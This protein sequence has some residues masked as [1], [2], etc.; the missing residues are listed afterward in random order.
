MAGRRCIA[1]PTSKSPFLATRP[2][3]ARRCAKTP[4]NGGGLLRAGMGANRGALG[5]NG[6]KP[7]RSAG[8]PG[9]A[10]RDARAATRFPLQARSPARRAVDCRLTGDLGGR[11]VRAPGR[12]AALEG[13]PGRPSCDPGGLPVGRVADAHPRRAREGGAARDGRREE[14]KAGGRGPRGGARRVCGR[15]AVV[16]RRVAVPAQAGDR[17]RLPDGK[18]DGDTSGGQGRARGDLLP[19]AVANGA[20]RADDDAPAQEGARG[21]PKDP[22][23]G[24]PDAAGAGACGVHGIRA[25]RRPPR[26]PPP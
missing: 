26:K 15:Q 19:C 5:Q 2:F 10:C 7:A 23:G 4:Q 1:M 22:A 24:V 8:W 6:T 21:Q 18:A 16:R 20:Q 3:C 17:D 25:W 9:R 13:L 11:A 12:G 14:E